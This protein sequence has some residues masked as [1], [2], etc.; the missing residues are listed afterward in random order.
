[1]R[2]SLDEDTVSQNKR[3]GRHFDAKDHRQPLLGK[4]AQVIEQPKPVVTAELKQKAE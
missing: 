4:E 1:M 2:I 3:A